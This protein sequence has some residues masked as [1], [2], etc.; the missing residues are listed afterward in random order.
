[1]G[2]TS[3]TGMRTGVNVI[4]GNGGRLNVWAGAWVFS[5][6]GWHGLLA[7]TCNSKLTME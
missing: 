5:A 2:E 6:L 4:G 3:E 1:L 7:A